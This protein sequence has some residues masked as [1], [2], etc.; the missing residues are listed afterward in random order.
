MWRVGNET[1][2]N[3]TKHKLVAMVLLRE[4]NEE[5]AFHV[6]SMN[7]ISL[8][9]CNRPYGSNSPSLNRICWITLFGKFTHPIFISSAYS[10]TKSLK[11]IGKKGSTLGNFICP[12]AYETFGLLGTARRGAFWQVTAVLPIAYSLIYIYLDE[13]AGIG[14]LAES[15]NNALEL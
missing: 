11:K 8:A 14:Q 10:F 13:W 2:W 6:I 3:G 4:N 12:G 9:T 15:L 5:N 7:W 1:G